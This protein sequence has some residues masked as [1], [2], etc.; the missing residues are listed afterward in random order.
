MRK[1]FTFE[2]RRYYVSGKDDTECEVKKAIKIRD[3]QEGVV[4][5][6]SMLVA[7]W[8][9]EWMRTYKK[10]SCDDKTYKDYQHRLDEYIL[11]VI[12][13]I[14][15]KDVKPVHL[16]NIMQNVSSMSQSRIDKMYQCLCQMFTVAENND[17]LTKS[18]TRGLVKPKGTKGSHRSITD[19]ER[20]IIL[21]VAENHK[22]GL[23]VKIMLY[24]G[25][26]TGE[27]VRIKMMHFD[28]D[29]KLLFVDGTKTSNAKR[30]VP[31]PDE[32]LEEIKSLNKDPFEYLFTNET[33]R[34]VQPHNRG[35]MWKSFKKAMHVEMGGKLYR[36]SIVPPCMVA[37]D[38][39]PYCLRHTFCTDLQDAGVPINVAKEL[40][41]H[42]D[43][44]LT[45]SIYTH[46]TETSLN[47]AAEMMKLFR[48]KDSKKKKQSM[49]K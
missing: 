24:C 35:R 3:L 38:L 32:I 18:P 45:A 29:K 21:K 27:T 34:Q 26:R 13:K 20:E 43:I 14:K 5:D 30:Y 16:Q 23:W 36:G 39:V 28:F 40:M 17:L 22:Y 48:N 46:Y 44:S 7:D 15:L 2:G 33:G 4:I 37:D 47:N 10:G 8:S 6:S 19:Q 42:S 49:N 31:V 41:G 11:P 12:G 9:K 25:L 1:A